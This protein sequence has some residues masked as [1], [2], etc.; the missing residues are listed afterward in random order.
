MGLEIP[1]RV[2]LEDRC[3]CCATFSDTGRCRCCQRRKKIIP[4]AASTAPKIA[5]G[6]K[7]ASTALLGYEGHLAARAAVVELPSE[8]READTL[9]F[10]GDTTVGTAWSVVEEASDVVGA[11]CLD[12][13]D[14]VVVCVELDFVAVEECLSSSISHISFPLHLY[15]KGQH[16]SPHLGRESS[17]RVVL[18]AFVWCRVAFCNCTSQ[19]MGWI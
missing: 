18:M 17:S 5:P 3:V 13:A 2:P 1:I 6:K 12:D 11:V 9:G 16:E 15:P 4:R 19:V 8:E 14:V 7:P 10:V